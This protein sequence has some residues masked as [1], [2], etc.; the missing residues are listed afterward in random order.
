MSNNSIKLTVVYEPDNNDLEKISDGGA[1]RYVN[2]IIDQTCDGYVILL[3]S[4]E[5]VVNCVRLAIH[6]KLISHADVCFK[7]GDHIVYPDKFGYLDWWPT[8][9]CDYTDKILSK[10]LNWEDAK[11]G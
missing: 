4:Q 2:R 10:L 7:F 5:M 9:F 3:T 8:G 1:E 6:N 11:D